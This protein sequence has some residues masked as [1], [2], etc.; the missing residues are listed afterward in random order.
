GAFVLAVVVGL[1]LALL[2]R[3]QFDLVRKAVRAYI[4]VLRGTPVLA[5]LFILYFGLAEFGLRFTPLQA[6]ILGLG[7]NGAAYLAE[8]FRAGIQSIHAGQMDAALAVGMTPLTAMRYVVL[9]QAVGVVVPPTANYSIALLKDTAVVSAVAA[10]EIMFRARDLV[11]E[12]YL[13]MQI[14]LLVAL[15]YLVLSFALSRLAVAL[16]RR[17]A[18]GRAGRAG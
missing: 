12:T 1:L 16:E 2:Q 5:Q 3:A 7:L 11:M 8:V 13:S 17:L 14:Y 18:V 9:P 10:P 6:A 15:M 4:E